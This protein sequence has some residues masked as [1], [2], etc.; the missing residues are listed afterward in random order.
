MAPNK[1][2]DPLAKQARKTLQPPSGPVPP[3]GPTGRK[4]EPTGRKTESATVPGKNP[5]TGE[6][7]GELL[8]HPPGSNGEV[9]RGPDLKPRNLMRAV[10]LKAMTDPGPLALPPASKRSGAA[11]RERAEAKHAMIHNLATA[12]QGIVLAAAEGDPVARGQMLRLVHDFH[13]IL[14]PTPDE[15]KS[16]GGPIL[17]KFSRPTQPVAPAPTTEPAEDLPAVATSCRPIGPRGCR[18]SL[19]PAEQEGSTARYY[20]TS[21]VDATAERQPCPSRRRR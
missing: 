14:Q 8:R 6:P 12:F 1:P 5:H 16:G 20:R 3:G 7:Q 13:E 4:T 17:P 11:K 10:C 9:R 21:A 2:E 19:A 18:G 15:T